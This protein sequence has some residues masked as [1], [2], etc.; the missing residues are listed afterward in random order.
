M[1]T[2]SDFPFKICISPCS[3]ILPLSITIIESACSIVVKRWAII[4]DVLFFAISTDAFW[5]S[6]SVSKSIDDVA[7]SKTKIG[8]L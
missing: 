4:I 2:L 7:S 8:G 5:I 3:M 1:S 6:F